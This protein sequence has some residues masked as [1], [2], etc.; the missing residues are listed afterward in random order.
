MNCKDVQELLPLHVGRDLEDKRAKL[1]TTHVQACAGCAS[2][3][4]EYRET[5]QLLHLFGPPPV[6]D[7]VYAGIRQRL[8]REIGREPAPPALP[9][10]FLSMFNPRVRYALATLLLLAVFGVSVYFIANRKSNLSNAGQQLAD[11]RRTVDPTART[12]AQNAKSQGTESVVSP[13]FLPRETN[14]PPLPSHGRKTD[15]DLTI[16]AALDRTR[17][18]GKKSLRIVRTQ[19]VAVDSPEQRSI[20][21]EV[22]PEGT[23]LTEPDAHP[24]LGPVTSEKTLRVEMQTRDRNIRIIWFTHQRIKQNS[25]GKSF[26]GIPEVRSDV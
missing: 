7:A 25:P 18:S 10:L 3:A 5:R 13:P 2:L 15:M 17:D 22:S 20:T 9:Q 16:A 12:D 23:R 1:V 14:R 26:K 19:S 6:S 4:A 21:A 11:N 24:A 8:L